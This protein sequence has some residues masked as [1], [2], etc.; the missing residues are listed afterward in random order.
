MLES[1]NMANTTQQQTLV[2]Y[3][4]KNKKKICV[5]TYSD[6]LIVELINITFFL[7]VYFELN[8]NEIREKCCEIVFFE[9][10]HC[11]RQLFS[12]FVSF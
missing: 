10:I 9:K 4:E 6:H 7:N 1:D 3:C 5:C 8:S 12:V 11:R 2:V